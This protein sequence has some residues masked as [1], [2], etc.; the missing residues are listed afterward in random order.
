MTIRYRIDTLAVVLKLSEICN[1]AC[2]YCYYYAPSEQNNWK[3][4]PKFLTEEQILQ[5][6]GW[7][8]DF[9]ADH[10]TRQINVVLHGGEPTLLD[11]ETAEFLCQVVRRSLSPFVDVSFAIQTNAYSISPAWRELIRR[12]QISIGVSVDGPP[13]INDV[14]RVTQSGRPTSKKIETTLSLIRKEATS[15][16]DSQVG[17]ICVVDFDSEVNEIVDF[18]LE[19]LKV[20]GINALLSYSPPPDALDDDL[21][22]YRF[23]QVLKALFD[24]SAV[25]P[26]LELLELK[27]LY[28]QLRG[29]SVQPLSTSDNF[30]SYPSVALTIYTDGTLTVDDSM[31]SVGAW[32]ESAPRPN[33]S[34]VSL[35][36]FISLMPIRKLYE[37]V[38]SVP[39]D[40]KSCRFSN[41][42]RGGRTH[43]RFNTETGFNNKSRYC[44]SYFDF[45]SHVTESLAH[46]G[47]PRIKIDNALKNQI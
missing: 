22:G 16:G 21:I 38:H 44:A 43:F 30:I 45:F 6:T 5:T 14:V 42:C 40:C 27:Y 41:V 17:A 9:V 10:E 31:A 20:S 28:A 11:V 39:D 36:E 15:H 1:L 23:A 34:A 4:R 24:A 19:K 33:L 18:L 26:E 46:A 32:Y 3:D 35:A 37:A 12:Q 8:R 2:T 47:M 13:E 7:L 25:H 29:Q